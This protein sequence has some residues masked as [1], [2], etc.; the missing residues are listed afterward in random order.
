MELQCRQ[1]NYERRRAFHCTHIYFVSICQRMNESGLSLLAFDSKNLLSFSLVI[2]VDVHWTVQH[3]H[4][5]S[6]RHHH[7]PF[8]THFSTHRPGHTDIMIT[9]RLR[10]SEMEFPYTHRHIC[11]LI[12][13]FGVEKKWPEHLYAP[14]RQTI[15]DSPWYQQNIC[16]KDMRKSWCWWD[17]R[18]IMGLCKNIRM[19]PRDT[20]WA[21]GSILT[22]HRFGLEC[23][24]L[25]VSMLKW[26]KN[27]PF[28]ECW[29]L[30][31]IAVHDTQCE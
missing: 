22:E 8:A 12:K 5:P 11:I 21:D 20:C 16:L 31:W 18:R 13:I 29:V 27:I 28:V 10:S 3:H 2:M 23:G 1:T 15:M 25:F 19:N 24:F 7:T 26:E 30:D 9:M 6:P 14:H 17:I 4:L